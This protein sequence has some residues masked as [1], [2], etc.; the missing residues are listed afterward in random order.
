MTSEFRAGYNVAY[1]YDANG[2]RTS[3][4]V[5]G[6]VESYTYDL[7]D[8]MLTAGAKSYTYD[9]AGRTVGINT[10]D[11]TTTLTREAESCHEES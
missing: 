9:A 6:T 8:K 2:N 1:T 11:G 10:P 7:G 3:K 4:T 5:N